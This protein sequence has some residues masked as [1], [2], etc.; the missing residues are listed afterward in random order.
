MK[1]DRLD[2]N[3]LYTFFAVAEHGG[4]SGAARRLSRTRSAV[5]QSLSAL[6]ASLERPLFDRVGRRL[7]MTR[8]GR[9]LYR[10][11]REYQSMLQGTVDEIMNEEGAIRGPIWLG[12]F[13]GFPSSRLAEFIASFFRSYPETSLRVVHAPLADLTARLLRGRLDFV[14][15]FRPA[16]P[17]N[18]RL[19]ATKLYD[20]G[21][22][23]VSGRS[24][25]RQGFDLDELRRVPIIDYYQRD[26]M[27]G[28]YYQAI[29]NDGVNSLYWYIYTKG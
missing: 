6:E 1:L 7:V 14:L 9:L 11:F 13:H 2:L 15:S 20:Q 23:L 19:A 26:W 27:S 24:F 21:L 22:V 12:L 28:Y 3:K 16:E 18:P 5:S 10:R 17:A 29:I 25:F 4:I 8:E